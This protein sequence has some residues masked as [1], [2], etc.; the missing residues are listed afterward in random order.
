MPHKPRTGFLVCGQAG[1]A[2]NKLSSCLQERAH[3]GGSLWGREVVRRC[4]CVQCPLRNIRTS[5]AAPV[6]FP[7]AT[8]AL[9]RGSLASPSVRAVRGGNPVLWCAGAGR[10]SPEWRGHGCFSLSWGPKSPAR[11]FSDRGVQGCCG[12]R[13]SHPST[14]A[15]G[16]FQPPR[17]TH[18][19]F[20]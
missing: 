17:R 10:Y 19:L 16:S 9:F 11:A 7:R 13:C 1:L 8:V 6:S 18:T 2:I 5:V 20:S 15:R 3:W 12:S 4:A 14:L